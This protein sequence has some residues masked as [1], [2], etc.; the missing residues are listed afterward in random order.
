MEYG[1][2][3]WHRHWRQGQHQNQA[4]KEHRFT[5]FSSAQRIAAFA[6]LSPRERCAI[7]APVMRASPSPPLLDLSI[8]LVVG[9]DDPLC[10]NEIGPES[11]RYPLARDD[12]NPQ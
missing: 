9:S 2:N 10:H 8:H 6:F 5:C 7:L 1:H 12:V 4:C 3:R 11:A